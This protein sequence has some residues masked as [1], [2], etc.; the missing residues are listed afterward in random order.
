[1]IPSSKKF[2]ALTALFSEPYGDFTNE[3]ASPSQRS[4]GSKAYSLPDLHVVGYGIM[5]MGYAVLK[6]KICF[7]VE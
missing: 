5:L 6:L 2:P 1:M 4:E 3:P 7:T